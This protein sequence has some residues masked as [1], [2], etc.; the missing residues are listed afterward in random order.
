MRTAMEAVIAEIGSQHDQDPSRPTSPIDSVAEVP[1]PPVIRL[2]IEVELE[3]MKR[4]PEVKSQ[5]H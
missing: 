3:G 5:L 1:M 4:Q 2:I